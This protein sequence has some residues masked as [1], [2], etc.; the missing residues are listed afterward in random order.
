MT[1]PETTALIA[2]LASDFDALQKAALA[3]AYGTASPSTIA[4]LTSPQ[5]ADAHVGALLHAETLA[6]GGLHRARLSAMP[7]R[8]RRVMTVRLQRIA[9][10]RKRAAAAAKHA[11]LEPGSSPRPRLPLAARVL[12]KARPYAFHAAYEA[13]CAERELAPTELDVP[14]SNVW[15]W[16]RARGLVTSELPPDIQRLLACSD[17]EFVQALLHD[18]REEENPHLTH[19]AVVEHWA[20]H[21]RTA[22]AWGR[23]AIALAERA[24]L[25]RPANA[26]AAELDALDAAY[27]DAA[28]LALRAH[29]ATW[30]HAGLR[31]RISRLAHPVIGQLRLK[32]GSEATRRLAAAEPELWEEITAA[33]AAHELSCRNSSEGCPACAPG[34]A[35]PYLAR[36]DEPRSPAAITAPIAL[37]AARYALLDDVPANI[38]WAVADAAVNT[39]ESALCGYGWAAADGTAGWGD[40]LASTSGEAEVIAVC[41]ALLALVD[42]HPSLQRVL[43]LCDSI[44]AVEAVRHAVNGSEPSIIQRTVL[45]PDGRALL[46]QLAPHR[47]RIEVRW[48]K[49]HI[50]HDLNEAADA[51]ARLALHRASGRTPESVARKS[52]EQITNSLRAGGPSGLVA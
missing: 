24:I 3:H 28:V 36:D 4:A 33:A 17:E 7:T 46:D 39:E 21:A 48:L 45:F 15:N 19:D 32:C 44:Q 18:A 42:R 13:A 30:R 35:A 6:R 27:Q 51:L 25:Q 22:Q 52:A 20:A 14:A 12:A 1:P 29:E 5:L 49:G 26:R 11:R 41:Q 31:R 34:L 16:A 37:D 50:G 23:Y 8:E 40:S 10:A 2:H 9:Q 43:V 38:P 47:D